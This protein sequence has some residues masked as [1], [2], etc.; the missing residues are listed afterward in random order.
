V[1]YATFVAALAGVAAAAGML[2]L[3]AVSAGRAGKGRSRPRGRVL[4]IVAGLGRRLGAPAP[5]GDLSARLDAAGRPLG[6]EVADLAALKGGAALVA[7][8]LLLPLAASLP[9]RLPLLAM[10]GAAAGGFLAPDAWLRRLARARRELVELEL[11]DLLDLLRVCIETGMTAARA[12]SE[13]A[14]VARTSNALV[15]SEW[16]RVAAAVERGVPFATALDRLRRRCPGPETGALVATLMRADRH[17]TP[18]GPALLA[19]SRTAREARARAIRDR[20]ARAAPK[21]QL[22]IAVLLVPSVLLLVAAALL[23]TLSRA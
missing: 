20:A 11:P 7:P 17:G 15:V 18:P 3:A 16:R 1:T 14:R 13:V 8:V 10:T 12:M 23:Q 22:V 21:M 2:E 4:A 19:Q 9:G 6:L 5:A